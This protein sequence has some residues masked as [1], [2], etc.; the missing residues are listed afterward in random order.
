MKFAAVNYA[1]DK[2]RIRSELMKLAHVGERFEDGRA[3]FESPYP[4]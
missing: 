2:S 3:I 1:A 4:V